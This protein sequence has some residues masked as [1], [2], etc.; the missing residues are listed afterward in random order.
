M[1][2]PVSRTTEIG[3]T[4]AGDTIPARPEDDSGSTVAAGGKTAAASIP[5]PTG[6]GVDT[7]AVGEAGAP[8]VRSWLAKGMTG[9]A[10]ACSAER[11]T[12]RGMRTEEGEGRLS[13]ARVAGRGCGDAGRLAAADSGAGSTAWAGVAEAAS[14]WGVIFAAWGWLVTTP[15]TVLTRS[16][17][18]GAAVGDPATGISLAAAIGAAGWELGA[19]GTS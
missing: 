11:I 8:A 14:G 19:D 10:V 3:T 9:V 17:G 6:L 16:T 1:G 13:E 15:M 5:D 12:S 7:G 18:A 2:D 4:G